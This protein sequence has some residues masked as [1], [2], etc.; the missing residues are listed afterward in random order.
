MKRTFDFDRE[1][2]ERLDADAAR[3]LRSSTKHLEAILR[4]YLFNES[5][6]L[7]NTR[8]EMIGEIVP[9]TKKRREA[10]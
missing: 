8:L 1:I 7:E 2:W 10:A 4:T 9:E 3:C 5:F 6:E